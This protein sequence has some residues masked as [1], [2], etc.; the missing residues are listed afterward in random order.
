MISDSAAFMNLQVTTGSTEQFMQ[1]ISR[2]LVYLIAG[3]SGFYVMAVEMLGARILAPYFG[4][5]VYVWGAIITV[6]MLGLS[7][8]Y[9]A[10][11]YL[12]TLETSLS[13]LGALLILAVVAAFPLLISKELILEVIFYSFDDPRLSAI[14]GSLFLFFLPIFALG[15]ISP[16]CV[17]LAADSLTTSGQAA[18]RLYFISTL[19]STIGTLL[20]SFYLVL[21]FEIDHMLLGFSSVSLF[22][23]LTVIVYD[24]NKSKAIFE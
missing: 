10:G 23:G 4:S 9:L 18:G 24:K 20:T 14:L 8:G 15:T 7:G 11:G 13:R 22:L 2:W 3:W 5:G 6:F 19:G 1:N 16:Y 12:S 17:R 21:L